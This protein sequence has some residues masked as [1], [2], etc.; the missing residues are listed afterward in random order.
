[1][2]TINEFIYLANRSSDAFLKVMATGNPKNTVHNMRA[3]QEAT[4]AYAKLNPGNGTIDMI[5]MRAVEHGA[6][7]HKFLWKVFRLKICKIHKIWKEHEITEHCDVHGESVLCT[8]QFEDWIKK[9]SY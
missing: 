4:H 2:I 9:N 6:A 1:V 8:K 3:W 5:Q 7:L